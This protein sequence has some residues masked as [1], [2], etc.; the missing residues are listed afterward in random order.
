MLETILSI[1]NHPE[2][3]L[4]VS[5]PFTSAIVGWGTNVLAIKMMFY[6]IEFLG[7]PPFLGWQGI[8]PAKAIKMAKINVKM[9]TENLISVQEM[10]RNLDPA[11][12]AKELEPL[13]ATMTEKILTEIMEEQSNTL[14]EALP[15]RA[16]DEIYKRV[17]K[18]SPEVIAQVLTEFTDNIDELFDL[19]KMVLDTLVRD[20]RLMVEMF[21]KVGEAEFKFIGNSGFYFGFLFGLIQTGVWF[22]YQAWW[23]LPLGGLLVGYLTNW[24]ALKMIFEPLEP[25]KIGPWTWQGLFLKRQDAVAIEY[26]KLVTKE[27][28]NADNIIEAVVRGP[29]SDQLFEIISRNVKKAIDSYAGMA[30]PFVQMAVGTKGYITM[31]SRACDLIIAE[32]PRSLSLVTDYATESLAIEKTLVEKMRELT[33]TQFEGLLRPAFQEDEWILILVGAVLGLLVGLGQLFFMF[34]GV[35]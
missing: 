35:Q 24:L 30:K 34:G 26:S 11:G 31:K 17:S 18:D 13:M 8:V 28:L 15:Q 1:V 2:F 4:Y 10:F 12:M 5:M 9:M 33:P 16:K 23:E 25:K 20:K 29:A 21:L 19:E 14:W 6:P 32:V 22:V 27:I 7:I 3:W